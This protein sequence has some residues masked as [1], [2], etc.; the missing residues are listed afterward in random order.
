MSME[1]RYTNHYSKVWERGREREREREKHNRW[2]KRER[3]RERIWGHT[4]VLTFPLVSVNSSEGIILRWKAV[5][6]STSLPLM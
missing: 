5:T 3:E 4:C 6:L 2:R 1:T